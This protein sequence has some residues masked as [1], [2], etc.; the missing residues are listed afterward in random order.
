MNPL[1]RTITATAAATAIGVTAG[2]LAL[3][4]SASA[5]PDQ[6]GRQHTTMRFVAHDGQFAMDDLGDASPQGPGMGD[7]VV[8]TQSLTRHGKTVGKVRDAAIGVDG[9]KHLF[10]ANGTISLAHGT[11]TFSGLVAQTPH[12]VMAVT[13]GTGKYIGAVGKI[14]F[15]FPGNKQLLTVT[16]RH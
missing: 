12:F 10:E 5:R 13:G 1:T 3:G 6:S 9:K 14:A 11:I 4:P 2:A 15:D 7:V 16:L 8:L